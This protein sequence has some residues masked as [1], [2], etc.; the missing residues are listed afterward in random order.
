VRGCALDAAGYSDQRHRVNPALSHLRAISSETSCG[1]DKESGIGG[2]SGVG[3]ESRS[4]VGRAGSS[5][6]A[7]DEVA[8]GGEGLS[9]GADPHLGAVLVEGDVAH[10]TEAVLD[11]SVSSG[12]GQERLGVGLLGCQTGDVVT[13]ILFRGDDLAASDLEPVA[14]DRA[15]LTDLRPGGAMA[16]RAADVGV[17]LGIGQR[18]DHPDLTTTVA[19]L[20]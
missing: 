9:D 4:D 13:D 16:A 6:Q 19:R 12:Q 5:E 11:A 3:A 10:V 2:S 15:D 20:W 7:D 17:L 1:E 8:A 14:L 18:P